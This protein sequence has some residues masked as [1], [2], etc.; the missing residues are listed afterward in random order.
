MMVLWIILVVGG[1]ILEAATLSLVS[2]WFA[3]GALAALIAYALGAPVIVQWIVF[4]A[5]SVI[6]LVF[7]RPIIKKL[8]PKSY[9]PTNGE[10][11]I[12]K[13]ALVIEKID[14]A[15][16]TG[17]VNINGVYWGASVKDDTVIDEGETV[18]VT[19]KG[20]AV[21]TVERCQ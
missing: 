1:S 6:L 17:R 19:A 10:L 14:S 11:D 5:V 8:M 18:I 4:V 15:A 12:G 13:K 20:G 3:A 16:G 7:T 9:T 21:V 2:I